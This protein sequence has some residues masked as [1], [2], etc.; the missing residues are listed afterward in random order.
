MVEVL[1]ASSGDAR[2]VAWWQRR[3]R[4]ARKSGIAEAPRPS[5]RPV[6]DGIEG[7]LR[8]LAF[9]LIRNFV[10]RVDVRPVSLALTSGRLSPR[11]PPSDLLCIAHVTDAAHA[12]DLC[13]SLYR[14]H[15]EVPSD[16]SVRRRM[17][18]YLSILQFVCGVDEERFSL[19]WPLRCGVPSRRLWQRG[20]LP[21]SIESSVPSLVLGCF[22]GYS[23]R[24]RRRRRPCCT[25]YTY[26]IY[27]FYRAANMLAEA[28][29]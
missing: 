9:F 12:S 19:V 29:W 18:K 27:P 4:G 28:N 21:V 11:S 3:R 13:Y 22:S 24:G 17:S 25:V 14:V 6:A 8:Q 10:P 16:K 23:P 26:T 15:W 5:A 20:E 7:G 1:R 2:K